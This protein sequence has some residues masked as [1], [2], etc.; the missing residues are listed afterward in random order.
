MINH[1]TL[2]PMKYNVSQAIAILKQTPLAI[3]TL[4]NGLSPEWINANEG[5]ESWSPYDVVGHLIHGEED[6]FINISNGELLAAAA[7]QPS[8]FWRV[9]DGGHSTIPEVDPDGY[10]NHILCWS[11]QDPSCDPTLLPVNQ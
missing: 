8:L 5:C 1:V 9:P 11:L 2:A 3:E 4:L 10:K 6:E 7:N